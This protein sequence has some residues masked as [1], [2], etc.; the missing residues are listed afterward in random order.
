M[1]LLFFVDVVYFDFVWGVE[2]IDLVF[3]RFLVDKIFLVGIVEG[4]N[5]WKNDFV[6]F[7]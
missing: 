5:I 1:Y 7:F 3:E 2:D 6:L 4:C